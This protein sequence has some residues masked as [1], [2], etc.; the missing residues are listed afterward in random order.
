MRVRSDIKGDKPLPCVPPRVQDAIVDLYIAS[1]DVAVA[2]GNPVLR[3][4]VVVSQ[5][6]RRQSRYRII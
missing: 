5:S 6:Y 2:V 1:L 4:D 3:G